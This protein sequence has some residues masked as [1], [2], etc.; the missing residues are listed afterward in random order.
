MQV[1]EHCGSVHTGPCPRISAIEYGADG[2]RR[3][4]YVDPLRYHEFLMMQA[5]IIQE[6]KDLS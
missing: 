2:V 3:V 5:Q 6:R 4:E 1:C